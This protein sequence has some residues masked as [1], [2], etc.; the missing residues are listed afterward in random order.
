MST[1]RIELPPKLIPVFAGEADFRGAY[2]GRGSAKTRSFAKMTAVKGF[3]FAEAGEEGVLLCAREFMNSLDDSSLAEVKAAILS[4]E[5]LA[6]YFEIGEKFVR[7][8][9]RRIE[10]AFAGLRH[11]IDS[12]KSKSRIRLLWVDEAEPVS[13]TAWSKAINSVREEGSEIWVTWNPESPRSATHKRF[14]ESP[15]D[16]ARIVELNWRDNPWF[17]ATLDRKRVQDMEKRPDT[18]DHVWEG[19]FRAITEGAYFAKEL[20]AARANDRITLVPRDPNLQVRTF[21]DLGRRDHTAIWI[22]QFNG[23]KIDVIDFIEGSGQAPGFYFA[24][25]RERGYWGCMVY[26]PHDGSRVGPENASGRS[27][28]DQARDAGFDVQVILNQGAGAAML[29]IDAA[30][31]LFPR[32][33]FDQT[34]TKDG[35]AALA[36][37]HEKQDEKREVGLG[38]NHDWSSHAADAFGLMCVAYEEPQVTVQQRRPPMGAGGWMG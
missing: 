19:G 35:L 26:L 8:R 27:Y 33:W 2:G 12:I 20:T 32:I 25:L 11:N 28:E 15:P 9:N 4:E 17:P 30:R 14:R 23:R 36:A 3:Q 24:E 37:Y 18:Y 22:A 16:R 10:Y 1:A 38:P 6:D 34:K 21:W 13:E 29:R 7:S 31:R 5:W